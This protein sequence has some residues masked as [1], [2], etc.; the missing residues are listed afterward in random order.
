[1]RPHSGYE[2]QFE[3]AYVYQFLVPFQHPWCGTPLFF[4]PFVCVLESTQTTQSNATAGVKALSRASKAV[5][6]APRGPLCMAPLRVA[7]RI[8][9]CLRRTHGVAGWFSKR[10]T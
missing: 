5:E 8:A 4:A 3:F 1:M 6:G 10:E 7:A 2:W 9:L